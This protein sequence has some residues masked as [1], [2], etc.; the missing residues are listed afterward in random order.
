MAVGWQYNGFCKQ[1][2][3][4]GDGYLVL[5]AA[6]QSASASIEDSICCGTWGGS[7]LGYL[8]VQVLDHNL[9]ATLV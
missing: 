2:N 6:Q 9:V 4:G 1:A 5:R 8:I 7:L 3:E